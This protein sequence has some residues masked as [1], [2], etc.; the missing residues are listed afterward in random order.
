[1]ENAEVF[2][3]AVLLW[4]AAWHQVPAASLPNDDAELARIAGFGRFVT[5]WKAIKEEALHG[6]VLC[7]DGRY[8]HGVVAEIALESWAKRQAFQA[9][10]KAANEARHGAKGPRKPPK[11]KGKNGSSLK[12]PSSIPQGSQVKGSEVKKE[13]KEPPTGGSKE[14]GARGSRLSPAWFADEQ[15]R[16]YA[17]E[18][19]FLP[20]EIDRAEDRFRDFW[21]G[22]AGADARKADWRA[23]WRNWIRRDADERA[24]GAG[25]NR[26][27]IN[28]P[29]RVREAL[30]GI[31]AAAGG[32]PRG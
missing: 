31:V 5:E 4:C 29:D 28:S 22:K 10:S 30:G 21:L 15:D 16:T 25:L 26:R 11:P 23:T 7:S 24:K 19:G 13:K 8:Y 32:R 2:R 3:S 27:G 17:A 12:E 20:D 18:Q 9:R 1:M 14:D 6:F